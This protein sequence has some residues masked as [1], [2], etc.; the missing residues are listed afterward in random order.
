M[1][2]LGCRLILFSPGNPSVI[3][4]IG[5]SVIA[6]DHSIRIM[7]IYPKV[8][9]VAVRNPDRAESPAS[10]QRPVKTGVENIHFIRILGIRIDPGII[11]GSLAKTPL[12]VHPHPGLA[13]IIRTKNTPLFCLH[14]SPDPILLGA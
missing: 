12:A 5:S 8:M 2:E 14:N 11:P 1:I 9:I 7:G 10:I 4:D 13:A 3:G 6:V